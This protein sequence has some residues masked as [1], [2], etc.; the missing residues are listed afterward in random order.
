MYCLLYC[1]FFFG[2]RALGFW[3]R[4]FGPRASGL[5]LKVEGISGGISSSDML[6]CQTH[7]HARVFF[8]GESNDRRIDRRMG[9]QP[10]NNTTSTRFTDTLQKNRTCVMHDPPSAPGLPPGVD[11]RPSPRRDPAGPTS[12]PDIGA[13]Q[14][15]TLHR[16][17]LNCM[18]RWRT[19]YP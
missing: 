3:P 19:R 13:G 11:A 14:T 1:L 9:K 6:M 18:S 5:G 12:G 10:D 8:G 2:L 17:A 4:A 15:G 7:A 16:A